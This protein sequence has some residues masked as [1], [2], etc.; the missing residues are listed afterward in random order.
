[1][2]GKEGPGFSMGNSK[3]WASYLFTYKARKHFKGEI[4]VRSEDTKEKLVMRGRV[5]ARLYLVF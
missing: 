5:I 4:H 1:M 2:V 3:V